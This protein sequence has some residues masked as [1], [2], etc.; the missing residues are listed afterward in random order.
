MIK[1]STYL[2]FTRNTEEVFNFY[3]SIFGGQFGNNLMRFGD[4]P[5]TADS[6]KVAESDMS[7]I[8]HIELTLPGGHILMG[9]D[10][11][12]SMGFNLV[13]GNNIHIS[14]EPDTKAETTRLFKALSDG[15]KITMDLQ[16]MFWGG[17]YGACTDKFGIQWMFNFNDKTAK[18]ST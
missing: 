7:L 14:I 15:G 3:R 16:N 5:K 9:T 18:H 6:P 2:N 12:E 13:T 4:M 11:P 10:A 8:I 17:Y 1:V